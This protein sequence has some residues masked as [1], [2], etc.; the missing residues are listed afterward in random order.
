MSTGTIILIVVIAVVV[1]L[2]LWFVGAYNGFV[3][4]KNRV[5][6][7]FATMDVYMK[8]RFDLIPNLV[9]TVKGYAAHE[10]TTL[11]NVVEARNMAQNAKTVEEKIEGEN[12]LTGTLKTL[13]A[14]AENY[15]D[16]KANQNFLD[17]QNQLKAVEG[18]IANSRKYY[19]ATVREYNTKAESFPSNIIAGMFHFERKPMFE[20]D[21]EEERQN[22]N[23]QF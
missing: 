8:K 6:E 4:L 16:L 12:A 19:N 17:L 18:D 23:V 11:Q 9:E 3:K 15:P 20:V 10:A 14:V 1:I 5:E 2:L 21:S 13:F 7:A 22:V